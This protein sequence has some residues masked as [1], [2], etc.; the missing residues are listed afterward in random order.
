MFICMHTIAGCSLKKKLYIYTG[1]LAV[2]ETLKK[3]N[4]YLASS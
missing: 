1:F 3:Y 2:F 4:Y